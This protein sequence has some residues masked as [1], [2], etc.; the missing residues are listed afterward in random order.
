MM[1]CLESESRRC[2]SQPPQLPCPQWHSHNG[3]HYVAPDPANTQGT[4]WGWHLPLLEPSFSTKSTTFIPSTT[5]NGE[6]QGLHEYTL[7]RKLELVWKGSNI[8]KL[9]VIKCRSDAF[10]SCSFWPCQRPHAFRSSGVLPCG[11]IN[12]THWLQTEPDQIQAIIPME[13]WRGRIRLALQNFRKRNE[14]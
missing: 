6:T 13:R 3:R 9:Q 1:E 12:W 11:V 4:H 10:L 5:C 2:Q 8:S 7:S 14:T